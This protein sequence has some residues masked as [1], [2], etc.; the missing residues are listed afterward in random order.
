MARATTAYRYNADYEYAHNRGVRPDVR[1]VRGNRSRTET[2]NVPSLIT[3]AKVVAVVLVVLA[4]V[5]C[6]RVGLASAT[7]S[8]MLESDTLNSEI[9]DARSEGTTLE[10]QQSSLLSPS[11]L[12][13][14]ASELN[15]SA[16]ATTE[17]IVL[18]PDVVATDSEGNL[19]L[20]GTVRNVAGAQE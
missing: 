1:V 12:S 9:S 11:T 6:L 2:S 8:E 20:S 17:T 15:M 19:S 10:M 4:V 18:D 3:L 13:A 14:S 7:V 16:P 5:G